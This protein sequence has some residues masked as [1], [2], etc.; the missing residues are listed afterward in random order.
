[1]CL[2]TRRAVCV[3]STSSAWVQCWGRLCSAS[4]YPTAPST[5]RRCSTS[6]TTCLKKMTTP[7]RHRPPGRQWCTWVCCFRYSPTSTAAST[8]S[9]TAASP[10]N[11]CSSRTSLAKCH[12]QVLASMQLMKMQIEPT[13]SKRMPT[14]QLKNSRYLL[15]VLKLEPWKYKECSRLL[16]DF[17][18]HSQNTSRLK[19]VNFVFLL[20]E[21]TRVEVPEVISAEQ[22]CFRQH[23]KHQRCLELIS[24][25]FLW[26]RAVQKCKSQRWTALF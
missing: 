1:M 6:C 21:I 2:G 5:Y 19:I 26:I 23:E 11:S 12:S 20:I 18:Q 15:L 13:I 10:A 17:C 16:A 7:S 14:L 22:R 4:S 3:I 25:D 8:P 9:S 24:S